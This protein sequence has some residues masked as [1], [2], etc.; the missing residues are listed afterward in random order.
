MEQ[1]FIEPPFTV[2]MFNIV[3]ST[4]VGP[5]RVVSK[6]DILEIVNDSDIELS[7]TVDGL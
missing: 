5:S 4:M 1:S 6:N 7:E 2:I 3:N